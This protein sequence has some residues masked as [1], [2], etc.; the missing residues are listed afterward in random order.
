MISPF[1]TIPIIS[2]PKWLKLLKSLLLFL[3]PFIIPGAQEQKMATVNDVSTQIRNI[4]LINQKPKQ[5]LSYDE[6]TNFCSHTALSSKS[7]CPYQLH[8]SA[9]PNFSLSLF[10]LASS[11]IKTLIPVF[12]ACPP[13]KVFRILE[14][15]HTS[16]G[17]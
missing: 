11:I 1:H 4:I 3:G 10:I 8:M 6:L 17:G 2:K 7:N 14:T 12:V 15:I 13:G 5:L 16:N 9:N